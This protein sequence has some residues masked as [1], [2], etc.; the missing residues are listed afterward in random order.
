MLMPSIF[1]DNIF[2]DWM[3][4]FPFFDDQDMQRAEKKLMDVAAEI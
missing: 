3:N 2:D 4:D 1:N